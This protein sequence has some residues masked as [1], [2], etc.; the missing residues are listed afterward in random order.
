MCFILLNHA[1]YA[2]ESDSNRY[3]P[4]RHR[5][6]LLQVSDARLLSGGV[7]TMALPDAGGFSQVLLQ[8]RGALLWLRKL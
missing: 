3:R 4:R 2:P 5:Q 8:Q 6:P 7:F 1:V